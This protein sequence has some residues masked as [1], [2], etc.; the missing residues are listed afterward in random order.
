MPRVTKSIL[1]FVH[2]R[3][4]SL[5]PRAQQLMRD[6]F[7]DKYILDT[8]TNIAKKA[9]R[10]IILANDIRMAMKQGAKMKAPS[11]YKTNAAAASRLENKILAKMRLGHGRTRKPKVPKLNLSKLY[12]GTPKHL[13][14]ATKRP[15]RS[16][17]FAQ[18]GHGIPKL[19]L[20]RIVNNVSGLKAP[21][22]PKGPARR[23]RTPAIVPPH[24]APVAPVAPVP[25]PPPRMSYAQLYPKGGHAY[26]SQVDRAAINRAR[27]ERRHR[28]QAATTKIHSA[29]Q[30]LIAG[31]RELRMPISVHAMALTGATEEEIN[32][33]LEAHD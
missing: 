16:Q 32:E 26:K 13:Y 23:R 28:I 31:R 30:D 6:R 11:G 22:R 3:N 17:M 1:N 4:I 21:T 5:A 8:A 25:P 24:I 19:H 27:A 20:D 14:H 10:S 15:A 18:V 29:R 12:Q 33:L 7:L 2:K 9:G